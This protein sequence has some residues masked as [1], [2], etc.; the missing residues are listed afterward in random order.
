MYW[1]WLTLVLLQ[2]TVLL[3]G[4]RARTCDQDRLIFNTTSGTRFHFEVTGIS[5]VL[6]TTLKACSSVCSVDI[7]CA[8]FVWLPRDSSGRTRCFTVNSTQLSVGT[9]L[10]A[11]SYVK[12]RAIPPQAVSAV[13][14][15][16]S[17]H[18]FWSEPMTSPLLCALPSDMTLSAPAGTRVSAQVV[19]RS[20]NHV[21]LRSVT[22]AQWSHVR[23]VG[24]VKADE[25]SYPSELG[26]GGGWYPDILAPLTLPL[27]IPPNLTVS[28]WVTFVIPENV[29]SGNYS[30]S[31]LLD[32]TTSSLVI[33]TN[34][35]VFQLSNLSSVARG[36]A[37]AWG[38]DADALS[39]YYPNETLPNI[40]LEYWSEM[41][42]RRVPPNSLASDWACRRPLTDIEYLLNANGCNE[43]LV[44]A[45]YLHSSNNTSVAYVTEVLDTVS[46]RLDALAENGLL[47]Q[48]YVYA[49]DESHVSYK[50]ALKVLFSAVKAR[51]PK[52]RTLSVLPWIP[53]PSL[54][55]D[56]WVVQYE[57]LD[58][59]FGG[60]SGADFRR[61]VA[62]FQAAGKEVWGYHCISP[63]GFG[64]GR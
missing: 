41:C 35:E 50:D 24:S 8:G 46:P 29:L 38:F 6:G 45:A 52:L 47:E 20:E 17:Q 51:W 49:F 55:L 12:N 44:N 13:V 27:S 57:F 19:I 21:T 22:P 42:A 9:D 36:F 60:W 3:V 2:Q 43:R 32:V 7:D 30:S 14:A 11:A 63:R 62:A 28:L 18:I 54:P 34:L 1:V 33:P 23:V 40:T 4:A 10:K 26:S 37:D 15:P 48:S 56:I 16:A 5:T 25:Q 31:L 58:V 59:G 61:G 53:D 64:P 39:L